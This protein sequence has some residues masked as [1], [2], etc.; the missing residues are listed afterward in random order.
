MVLDDLLAMAGE[1]RIVAEGAGLFPERVAPLL[2]DLR[3]GIWLVATPNCIQHVR[4][5]LG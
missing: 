4:R 5:V 1:G 2:S 3:S